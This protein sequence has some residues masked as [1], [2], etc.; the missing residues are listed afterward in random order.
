M[1]K[2]LL[3]II[4]VVFLAGCSSEPSENKSTESNS[5]NYDTFAACLTENGAKMYGTDWCP[6]CKTQKEMFGSS[7]DIVDYINCEIKKSECQQAGIEG[8]PTWVFENGDKL[9]GTQ[10]LKTLADRTNCELPE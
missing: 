9:P 6:H 3:L 10:Q 1:K 7:F 8:Y 4:C 2:L 5:A